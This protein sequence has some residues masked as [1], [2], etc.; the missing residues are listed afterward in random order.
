LT[1][2]LHPATDFSSLAREWDALHQEAGGIP[3]LASPFIQ[4][5]LEQFGAGDEQIALR[6]DGGK[7][8]CAAILK[9]S[10]VAGW[11]SFQPSQLPL[12]P[13]LQRAGATLGDAA[14]AELFR[15]LPGWPLTIG[16]T[17]LDPIMVP[18][19][20]D[21]AAVTTLDYITTAWVEVSGDF[22]TYWGNR[23]K[24]LRDNVKKLGR[25]VTSEGMTARLEEIVD[26][27]AMRS[28]VADYAK[29][30]TAGWKSSVGTAVS[31]DTAQGRFYVDMM[32]RLAALKR[33]RAYRYWF[34][35]TVATMDLCVEHG[36][37]M[38]V[39]K[40]A[41]DER[42]GKFSPATLMREQ[43]FRQ[44]FTEG[45]I[46]RV[47]FYG[48]MMEWHTRWTEHSRTLYHANVFR[49]GMVRRVVDLAKAG[50]RRRGPV[51]DEVTAADAK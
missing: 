48:P 13:F 34:D 17:Q 9:R 31:A 49:S 30:E 45:R 19:P 32:E 36:D 29:L 15:A 10:G 25:K 23:G 37:V 1:W 26:P 35:D 46:R 22:E 6:E 2:R 41:Y 21:G 51:G 12:G 43:I 28:A 4:S 44:I 38:V 50:L 40:T 11:Q 33:A 24:N 16:F 20:D 27:A 14:I 3:F 42:F 47:E 5:A 18:R 7:L 39:L 8:T